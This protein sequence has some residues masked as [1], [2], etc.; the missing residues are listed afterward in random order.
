MYGYLPTP[1]G[2]ELPD[3]YYTDPS[4]YDL[5]PDPSTEIPGIAAGVAQSC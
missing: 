2:F 3:D 5:T 1:P 4:Q